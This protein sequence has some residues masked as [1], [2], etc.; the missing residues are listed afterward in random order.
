MQFNEEILRL[1]L[2]KK[3]LKEG[4]KRRKH[5]NQKRT[6]GNRSNN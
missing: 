5:A 6:E 2:A 3:E 1:Q 4:N